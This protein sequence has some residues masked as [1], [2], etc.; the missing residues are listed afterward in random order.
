[1]SLHSLVA[2]PFIVQL[3]HSSG[4]DPMIWVTWT[5]QWTSWEG[6][7]TPTGYCPQS[8]TGS[9]VQSSC[10]QLPL[11]RDCQPHLRGRVPCAPK[12]R[13]PSL[14]QMWQD[15][16]EPSVLREQRALAQCFAGSLL[17]TT[18]HE[19]S[20]SA[21]ACFSLYKMTQVSIC[22]MRVWQG[23]I[24]SCSH[25]PL[26]H[27]QMHSR[28]VSRALAAALAALTLR[29]SGARWGQQQGQVPSC[30]GQQGRQGAVPLACMCVCK[31]MAH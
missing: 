12:V 28:A 14:G 15:D 21:E 1:M 17:R 19:L 11:P 25:D 10:C 7:T 29:T 8:A 23:R 24:Q 6:G 20:L 27:Q 18:P 3:C 2:L 30:H 26:P 4:R 16:A 13:S 22:C 5:D 31:I 9:W